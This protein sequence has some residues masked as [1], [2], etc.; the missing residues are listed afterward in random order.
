[1]FPFDLNEEIL[2]ETEERIFKEYE[3]NFETGQLTGRCV[4][5]LEAVKVWA[6]LALNIARYRYPQYSWNYGSEFENIIGQPQDPEYV[7]SE[8]Q[9]MIEECI[10]TNPH[11]QG[12]EKL[13]CSFEEGVLSASCTII[14]DY[15]EVKVDV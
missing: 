2:E 10:K 4:E 12:I 6:Y 11:I 9:R 7:E 14:T 8:I 1:M 15:G 5:G 13:Q 3:I